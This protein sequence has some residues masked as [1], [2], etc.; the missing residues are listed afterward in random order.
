MRTNT[1]LLSATDFIAELLQLLPDCRTRWIRRYGLYTSRSRGTWL[2]KPPLVRL[3][4]EGW[5]Q[6]H[7]SQSP[8]P[9]G[10]SDEPNPDGSVSAR[11]SCAAWARLLAKVY[12][13]DLLVCRQCV[14]D[15]L[16]R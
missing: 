3:A 8:V 14:A 7:L 5:K 15:Y 13:A 1:K 11:E 9:I 12:E 10:P 4:P 16:W 6:D 2:R